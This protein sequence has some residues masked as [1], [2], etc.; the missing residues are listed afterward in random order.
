M[1]TI[2]MEGDV[3]EG[4]ST[5][6]TGPLGLGGKDPSGNAIFLAT[7]AQGRLLLVQTSTQNYED[8]GVAV[9]NGP[10]T[11]LNFQ[12]AAFVVTDAG[13]GTANVNID[14]AGIDH[15]A[16]TGFVG[17]E[18]V[19]HSTVNLT[20][21]TGMTGGGDITAS[22]TFNVVGVNSITANASNIDLVNDQAAP[23]VNQ[24]Y[25]TDGAGTKG[26]KPDPAGGGNVFGNQPETAT[27]LPQQTTT[28]AGFVNALTQTY[29]PLVAGDYMVHWSGEHRNTADN[30]AVDTQITIDGGQVNSYR[31]YSLPGI[32]AVDDF[33][34]IAGHAVVTRGDTSAF[35]VDINFSAPDN[36]GT[37]IVR[38]LRIF[39][40][41]VS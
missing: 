17:N 27:D 3:L 12:D 16:L 13:G 15:D 23:G 30:A 36:G 33:Q 21:G 34:S 10:H 40:Y 31:Y 39:I 26:W 32:V 14:E 25:G 9:P 2:Q 4:A 24:V 6:N 28:S 29:T 1:P 5:A 41:R 7:D 20:A 38:N 19:D 18:H 37:A 8:A 11:T 35:D 22:R